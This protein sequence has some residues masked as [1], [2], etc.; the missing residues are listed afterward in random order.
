MIKYI[1]F[2]VFKFEY[3]HKIIIWCGKLLCTLLKYLISMFDWYSKGLHFT[4]RINIFNYDFVYIMLLKFW[5][6]TDMQ[7][8]KIYFKTK[9]NNIFHTRDVSFVPP[10]WVRAL[11]LKFLLSQKSTC[12]SQSRRITGNKH[13]IVKELI[14]IL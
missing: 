14:Y 8:K 3:V 10:I 7:N 6:I 5:G 1:L 4:P 2:I 11:A 12:L 13:I 9:T